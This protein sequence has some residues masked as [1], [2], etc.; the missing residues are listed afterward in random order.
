[1][2]TKI[3]LQ[4][5]FLTFL[6]TSCM[7]SSYYQVYKTEPSDKNLLKENSL[8]YED[9]NCKVF[10]DFWSENGNVGF[11]FF[12]KTNG[13]INL[14]LKESYFILNGIANNYYLNRIYTN[15]K[16][17]GASSVSSVGVSKS[18]TGIN[19]FDF[20]QTNKLLTTSSSGVSSTQGFSV[21]YTEES[22]VSIPS[23]TSKIITE[24]NLN[25]SIY[26]DCD[27]NK[28][29][30]KKQI[31]T[32]S[33]TKSTSPLV[34]SNRIVYLTENGVIPTK[35]ENEF[36]VTEITN[37]SES[38]IADKKYEEFCNQKGSVPT[39]FFKDISPIKFYV[40]YT[41]GMDSWIH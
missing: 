27:L 24:Y 26:R 21:A 20:L 31:R 23:N 35:F 10:Y 33:F 16:N 37:Y 18:I 32:K 3:Y 29:P 5:A 2:K 30:T 38:D 9:E 22:T 1:M 34:F 41:K 36:Y 8:V 4:F 11:R 17:I 19:Y 13:T 12:N 39:L 6:M 14:N 25:N 7:S 40:K 28:F 15:S